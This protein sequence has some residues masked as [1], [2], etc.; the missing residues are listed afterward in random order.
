MAH[1]PDFLVVI[2]AYN[3]G[4]RLG[5]FLEELLPALGAAGFGVDVVVV[6]DGSIEGESAA[7]R[8]VVDELRGRF[9]FL[10]PMLRLD[11]NRGK[12][13]AVYAAWRGE[14]AA[15]WL[16]FVDADGAVPPREV[17]RLMR[18]ARDS[19]D[20]SLCVM[21]ARI[22]ML[23]HEVSRHLHRHLIGRVFATM[24]H[25]LTGTGAYD[26]QC[27]F[28]IVPREV[29]GRISPLLAEARYC[30]DVELICRLERIGA[31]I[32]EVPIDWSDRP[33]SKVRL[34][35]DSIDMALALLRI[36]K[37]LMGAGPRRAG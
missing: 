17:V 28:K 1:S 8:R 33:G 23:G 13:G 11:A 21:A 4:S 26:T 7:M 29:F 31:R 24:V 3:E 6:D 32:I 34:G 16:A 15:A 10:R 30:F 2:P 14:G 36:R 12:G 27:G 9:G 18:M 37:R 25:L 5:R 20:R 19:G 22:K 35:R